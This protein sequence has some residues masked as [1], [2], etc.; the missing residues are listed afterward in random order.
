[1]KRNELFQFLATE[2]LAPGVLSSSQLVSLALNAKSGLSPASW[3]QN[4][5]GEI[6]FVVW[7]AA[8]N[9]DR[10]STL[11][12]YLLSMEDKQHVVSCSRATCS[13]RNSSVSSVRTPVR[14][15]VSLIHSRLFARGRRN[16][17]TNG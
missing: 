2:E 1:M 6:L 17:G 10:V 12:A 14:F 7:V 13:A 3:V 5:L 11:L 16:L 15:W 9:A 4:I 8:S